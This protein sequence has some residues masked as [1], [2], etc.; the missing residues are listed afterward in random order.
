MLNKQNTN[1]VKERKSL[2][3]MVV[4]NKGK[5]L[6]GAG[7]VTVGVLAYMGYKNNE[8][9]KTVKAVL[10]DQF[11]LNT[12]QGELNAAVSD[13]TGKEVDHMLLTRRIAEEGALEEAI[14]SVNRKIEYRVKKLDGCMK[15]ASEIA[16][17]AKE[18]YE[19]ELKILY[20]DRDNFQKIWDDR[21]V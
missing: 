5:I 11:K 3:E 15:E 9:I 17:A 1:E 19:S 8:N 16:L 12:A 13:I 7:I 18:K 20:K 6:V 2:K 21:I 4:E 10:N 14:K